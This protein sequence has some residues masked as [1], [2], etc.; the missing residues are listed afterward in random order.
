M[1][2]LNWRGRA[3]GNAG[4]KE[5]PKKP[6]FAF[7]TKPPLV[8]SPT[9]E[10]P[11]GTVGTRRSRINKSKIGAGGADKKNGA[12]GAVKQQS[13]SS[14]APTLAKDEPPVFR[15]P[16]TVGFSNAVAATPLIA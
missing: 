13:Q 8:G 15:P 11:K 4:K 3:D 14:S 2:D 5:V 7:K 10:I 9:G 6:Q 16:P 1:T 12:G